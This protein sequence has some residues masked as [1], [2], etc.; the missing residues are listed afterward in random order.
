M[1]VTQ[2][3]FHWSPTAN[4]Y[5]PVKIGSIDGTDTDPHDR[6]IIRAANATY[7]PNKGIVGDPACTIFVTRLNHVTDERSLQKAFSKFGPIKR[8]R[9]I[10]DMVTGIS[11]GYAFVEY[12]ELADVE[13]SYQ[14]TQNMFLINDTEI[15]VDYVHAR[16]MKGWVPRRLGG[17]FGGK[18]ESGQLRF[19]CRDRPFRKPLV[20]SLS[21][22]FKASDDDSHSRSRSVINAGYESKYSFTITSPQERSESKRRYR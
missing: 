9:I 11:K 22:R 6:A 12:F 7:R 17:G 19:G 15:L 10:R 21:S 4:V 18:K 14:S 1:S 3:E 16:A 20:I 2:H 8:V 5:D 13:R